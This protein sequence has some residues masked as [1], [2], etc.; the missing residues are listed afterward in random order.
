MARVV[1]GFHRVPVVDQIERARHIKTRMAGNANYPS[2][3]PTLAAFGNAIDKLERAYNESRNGDTVKMETMRL[4]RTELLA[5][6]VQLAAYVQEASEGDAEK[7]LS[8]GFSI[9]KGKTPHSDT[10]GEV[11]DLRLSD[12]S[13][14][15]KVLANWKAAENAVNYL[16]EVS[17]TASFTNYELKGVTTKTRKELSSFG[18]GTTIWIRIVPLGRENAG[19]KSDPVSI[20]V[21]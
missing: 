14:S 18:V 4:R 13:N 3:N 20:Q 15:G 5:L 9:K 6:V 1:M 10:A 12:G 7:I 19:T 2:P 8:S 11:H 16:I 17:L 21:R